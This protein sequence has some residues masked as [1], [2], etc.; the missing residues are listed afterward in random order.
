MPTQ[1]LTTN[2]N[3]QSAGK[4][5]HNETL[6]ETVSGDRTL[7]SLLRGNYVYAAVNTSAHKP[8]YLSRH[9]EYAR[10]SYEKL[11]GL[12]PRIDMES[13]RRRITTLLDENDMPMLG[14]IVCV[15]LVPPAD[16]SDNE[17]DT[18]IACDRSTIYRGYELISLR[19]TAILTNYEI[20]FSGHRTAVSLTTTDYMQAFAAR[21][22]AHIALRANRAQRLV[23]CGEYPVFLAKDGALYTPPAPDTAPQCLERELMTTAC[24][25]AGI[26]VYERNI[27]ASELAGADEIMVFNHTGLQSV[28]AWGSYYY[29]NLLARRIE[30]VL[31]TINR[32]GEED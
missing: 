31:D 30:R 12:S 5:Y 6:T 10:A 21:K 16:N 23:S 7:N 27:D 19:P 1:N 2:V 8:L 22:G 24:D 20:P 13:L 28:L 9:M 15:Y 26:K 17:P 29:Y 11:Y 32:K 25:M 18:I 3:M 4:I 14:N